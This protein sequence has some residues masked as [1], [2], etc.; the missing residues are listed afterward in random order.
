MH[1]VITSPFPH[2]FALDPGVLVYTVPADIKVYLA[3]DISLQIEDEDGAVVFSPE[4]T[5]HYTVALSKTFAATITFLANDE[6]DAGR[7]GV[8]TRRTA[9]SQPTQFSELVD[10]PGL[11][12]EKQNDRQVAMVQDI[13]PLL[14][15]ALVAR[16]G[17]V[18]PSLP[19][20]ESLAGSLPVLKADYSGWDLLDS[21]G[22]AAVMEDMLLGDAGAINRVSAGLA[23][24]L[25]L[26]EVDAEMILLAPHADALGA[27]YT[28]LA[29]LLALPDL[30]A[31]PE[32]TVV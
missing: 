29:A 16:R 8:L 6:L 11:S 15:R 24:V 1:G 9:N 18:L 3:S 4:Q 32:Y 22:L 21:D 14:S 19:A 20:R 25:A 10:F 2:V 30:V 5:T 31:L 7:M 23:A 26:A 12:V 17:E 27:I 13:W 28:N